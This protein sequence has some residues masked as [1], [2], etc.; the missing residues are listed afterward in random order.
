MAESREVRKPVY[1]SHSTGPGV[2][3]SKTEPRSPRALKLNDMPKQDST[4]NHPVVS[5]DEL[6]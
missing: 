5:R 2:L 6:S 3:D 1:S 4:T